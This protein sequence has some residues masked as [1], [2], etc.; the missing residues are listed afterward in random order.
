MMSNICIVHE[1]QTWL[2]TDKCVDL[3]LIAEKNKLC[4]NV[5]SQ[6]RRTESV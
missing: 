1:K 5:S 6:Q 2:D 3:D 4:V